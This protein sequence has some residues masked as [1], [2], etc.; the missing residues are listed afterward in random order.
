MKKRYLV[1]TLKW[2]VVALIA[3]SLMGMDWGPAAK[4]YPAKPITLIVPWGAGGGT[5]A[6]GAEVG[7]GLRL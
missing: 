7:H 6:M 1:G 5:D 4:D 2:I 3:G